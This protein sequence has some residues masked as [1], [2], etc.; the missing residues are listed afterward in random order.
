VTDTEARLLRAVLESPGDDTPRLAYA[1]AIQDDE[2]ERAE[3]IRVQCELAVAGFGEVKS[4]LLLRT[5]RIG[6]LARRQRELWRLPIAGT[7]FGDTCFIAIGRSV[8]DRT[9]DQPGGKPSGLIR[10]GFV[11]EVRLPL[12]VF[13]GG[14][15]GTCG[16]SGQEVDEQSGRP[17]ATC[18][19]CHGTGRVGGVAKELFSAQPVEKIS[20]TDIEPAQFD[21]LLIYADLPPEIASHLPGEPDAGYPQ[22]GM[23]AADALSVACVVYGR[24][25]AGLPQLEPQGVA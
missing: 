2:P 5:D 7:W 22:D 16:G 20:I 1:D 17:L 15:C 24:E 4:D 10:R 13:V 21:D 23:S 8:F 9:G 6:D 18:Y 3:F 12:A 25:L 11:S 19:T 14:E